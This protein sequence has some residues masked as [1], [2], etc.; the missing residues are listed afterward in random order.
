VL[1][2]LDEIKMTFD[3]LTSGQQIFVASFVYS[4]I[5]LFEN[6]DENVYT[7]SDYPPPLIVKSIYT[8]AETYL[9]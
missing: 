1:K 3:K 6:F 8:L 9:I 4:Y 2:G 7:F 5:N